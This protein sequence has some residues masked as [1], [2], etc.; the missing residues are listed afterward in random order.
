MRGWLSQLPADRAAADEARADARHSD[1]PFRA[2]WAWPLGCGAVGVAEMVVHGPRQGADLSAVA[3]ALALAIAVGFPLG[4]LTMLATSLAWRRG[5]RRTHRRASPQ[6]WAVLLAGMV[7]T[8]VAYAALAWVHDAISRRAVDARDASVDLWRSV[9]VLVGVPAVG[10]VHLA[11][12]GARRWIECGP[13]GRV[14]MKIVVTLAFM[15]GMVHLCSGPSVLFFGTWVPAVGLISSAAVAAL[16]LRPVGRPLAPRASAGAGVLVLVLAW[17]GLHHV[18]ARALLLHDARVFPEILDWMT[19]AIDVDGDG[20]LPFWLGG[21]DCDGRD[22]SVASSRPE[23]PGNGVDDNCYGGDAPLMRYA[24]PREGVPDAPRLPIVLITID[25]VRAD[26]LELHGYERPTMP[27][28]T[29]FSRGARWWRRA[30]APSNHTAFSM[31]SILSGQSPEFLVSGPEA[32]EEGARRFTHWLPQR[33]ANHGYRT[34]AVNPALLSTGD[35]RPAELRFATLELGPFDY[36]P[37]N[38]GTMAKQV[39]DAALPYVRISDAPLFMWIHIPDPHARHEAHASFPGSTTADAY[40]N[41]LRWVDMQL[42]RLFVRLSEVYG[43]QV[44]VAVTADH[45][46]SLGDHGGWGHGYSL[47]EGEIHVPLLLK[48]PSLGGG[49]VD[50]PVSIGALTPTLLE[51]VG[52]TPGSRVTYAS[53]LAAAQHPVVS[54]CPFFWSERR[55]AVTLVGRRWKLIRN[56]QRGTSLLFDLDADP[57]ERNNLAPS[58]PDRLEQMEA[59]L[60]EALEHLR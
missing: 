21:G 3:L 22:G 39:V 16:W 25:T 55:M 57:F 49:R 43:D 46:E 37:K 12:L 40:D 56:R 36:Q 32:K 23:L 59:R 42:A 45:G 52:I 19:A 44:I 53:L 51:L 29:Q 47:Y 38:R 20:D 17:G 50:P 5:W 2:F 28:L 4:L 34:V 41:E 30:Y 54:G 27:A 13:L 15:A 31:L 26:H 8:L 60:K 9:I 10:L 11:I 24:V 48:A 1:F 35:L 6:R 14:S 33:L 18:G 58:E 7:V